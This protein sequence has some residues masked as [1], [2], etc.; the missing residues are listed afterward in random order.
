M[1]NILQA[2]PFPVDDLDDI[3]E[4][5]EETHEP[6]L[7]PPSVGKNHL[8]VRKSPKQAKDLFKKKGKTRNDWTNHGKIEEELKIEE[9]PKET[10]IKKLS[11]KSIPV[12]VE[13]E[14]DFS[15]G[16]AIKFRSYMVT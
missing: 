5:P 15:Q 9:Q 8:L 4:M 11:T 7:K 16:C 14:E 1:S 12:H 13:E 6:I 10:L 2:E 3:D